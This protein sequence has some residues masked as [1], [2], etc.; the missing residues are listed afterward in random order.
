MPE[1]IS[2][3]EAGRA[4]DEIALRRRQI[5]AEIDVPA[6]YWW[7]LA[8]GWIAL[9]C[10]TVLGNPWVSIVATVA[11]GVVHSAVATRVMDGRHRSQQLSVS[12]EVVSRNVRS[13]VIGFLVVLVAATVAIAL[14]VEALGAPQP[15]L[16]ASVVI[17]VAVLVGGPKLMAVVRRRADRGLRS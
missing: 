17:A 15:A 5:V 3:V 10:V 9:G 13:L 11:F 2:R 14:I 1:H 6:W 8:F 4:L 16:L 12:A 7:G